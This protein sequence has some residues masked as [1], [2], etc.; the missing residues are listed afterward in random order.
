[1]IGFSLRLAVAGGREA[2]TRLVLIAAA[3]AAGVAF[4]AATVSGVNAV[5]TQATRYEWLTPPDTGGPL[6]WEVRDDYY[7]GE[8]VGRIDLAVTGPG[9]PVPA[10]LPRLPGPGEYFVSP[11]LQRLLSTVPADQLGDRFP[12][13]AVG[14]IGNA[15]LP[16]PDSRVIVIGHS[17]EEIAKAPGVVKVSAFTSTTSIG[18]SAAGFDLVLGVVAA[19]LLFPILMLIGTA[20]RLSAARR[21]QRFAAM[22]LIGATPRQITTIAMVEAAV[23]AIVGTVVGFVLFYALRSTFARIPFT[24]RRFFTSDLSLGP[25]GIAAVAIGIPVAA[26]VVAWLS[27]RRVNISPL[28]VTRRVTP[29]PP[30]A[31]RLLPVLIGL[32][33]LAYFIPVG[34]RP[35]TSLGQV[36][37]F[38]PGCLIVMAGLVVAGPWLTM[39]ATRILA[40]RAGRPA[41]LIAA[42]RLA[43]NPKAAFRSVSGLILALFVASVAVGIISTIVYHRAGP[44]S[45]GAATNIRVL[46]P[47]R[48]PIPA[49]LSSIPGVQ[50]VVTVYHAPEPQPAA[51]GGSLPGWTPDGLVLCADI[52]GRPDFGQCEPGAQVAAVFDNLV[53]PTDDVKTIVWP[54]ADIAPDQLSKLEPYSVV[55]GTDGSADAI[56]RARTVLI[57]GYPNAF[58]FPGTEAEWDNNFARTLTGWKQLANVIIVSSMV[59]A[60]CSLAVSVVGGLTDRKRPFSMLRLTGV[61]LAALRRVVALETAVPLLSAA[62]VAVA[63][64]LLT[65]HLFLLAQMH[66][67]LEL[68]GPSY[69]AIVVAGLGVSLGIVASTFPL[70]RRITGPDTARNE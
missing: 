15:A 23:S 2:I 67:R 19:G 63:V 47:G 26:A 9:A 54:T 28:G 57:R 51:S 11:A 40:R 39:V 21:E 32:A 68:P 42:R 18:L 46:E 35:Q 69:A 37:A 66:Y 29:K 16:A 56:E 62:V 44:T 70:L 13:H 34:R 36:A 50:K 10:G 4:L 1:V 65:A 22:R 25:L 14:V 58:D 3:V 38:L 24:G 49:G 8:D 43:D 53:G 27:L 5:T 30:G 55:V 59:L 33:E 61:Q 48:G 41:G 31:W 20:T 17:P 7:R 6:L 45:G 64:G 60:G 12:G 52:A